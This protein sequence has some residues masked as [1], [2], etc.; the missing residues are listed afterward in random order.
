MHIPPPR[1]Q[2]LA[3]PAG[4]RR[5]PDQNPRTDL[6]VRFRGGATQT[7]PSL[8]A[9]IWQTSRDRTGGGAGD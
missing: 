7:L 2:T 6:H 4:G 9:T 1:S 8:A 3:A 5:D